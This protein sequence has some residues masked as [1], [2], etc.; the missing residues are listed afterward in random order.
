VALGGVGCGG[1][2]S[3]SGESTPLPQPTAAQMAASG[4]DEIPV[5]PNR[6]RIDLIAPPFSDPTHVTN[7][8]FP[9]S[10]LRSAVLNGRIDGK[11]FH[12]ET[13]LLPYTRVIE[14]AP[15]QRTETLVSQYAAFLDGRIQERARL[16]RTGGRR[17]GLVL[18]RGRR[19]LQSAGPDH[20]HDGQLARRH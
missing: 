18:R 3:E 20:L 19:R 17:I 11:P 9:I 8:L 16:L 7:P 4:L 1:G 5:A 6:D 2:E 12:T 15:G 10:D 13:T 14:W